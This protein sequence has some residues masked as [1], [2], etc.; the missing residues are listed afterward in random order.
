MPTLVEQTVID[1]GQGRCIITLPKPWFRYFGIQPGDK[2]EIETDEDLI[3]RHPRRRSAT[4]RIPEKQ[5][6]KQGNLE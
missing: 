2:L 4:R 3:I 6:G 1:V 5:N